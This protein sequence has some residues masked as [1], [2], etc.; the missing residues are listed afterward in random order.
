MT[1]AARPLR[2]DQQPVLVNSIF[3]PVGGHF[4][5]VTGTPVD[6]S[7]ARTIMPADFTVDTQADKILMQTTTQNIRYTLVTG[8]APTASHGFQLKSTDPP[9]LIMI[10]PGVILTVIEEAAS[11]VFN[12][13]FGR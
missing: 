2:A 5:L 8:T 12:F 11:A 7:T 3:T 1:I 10:T 4:P 13:Q 9:V 6:I